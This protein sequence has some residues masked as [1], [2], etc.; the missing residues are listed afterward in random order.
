[1]AK[2]QEI[3]IDM[4]EHNKDL[5][6]EFKLIHDNFAADP[7]TYRKEFNEKGQD[8]LR[9][10]QR[11]ENILC[12]KSEGGKYSKYSANLSEKFRSQLRGHFP[13]IDQ[14]GML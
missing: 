5:F 1:M 14:V 9:V 13:L 6:G 7:D 11:Y 12:G 3:Y 8:M 4:L 10:V 2:Y